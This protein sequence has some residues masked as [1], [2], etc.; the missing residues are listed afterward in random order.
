MDQMGNNLKNVTFRQNLI[1]KCSVNLSF[2]RLM[3]KTADWS[4]S[5]ELTGL[6]KYQKDW[7]SRLRREKNSQSEET[8]SIYE[9]IQ[10]SIQ[11]MYKENGHSSSFLLAFFTYVLLSWLH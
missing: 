3:K 11:K 8:D 7:K 1:N 2:Q 4:D 6:Y 9:A 5:S 10:T